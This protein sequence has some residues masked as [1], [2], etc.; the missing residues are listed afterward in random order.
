MNVKVNYKFCWKC[1]DI[2]YNEADIA[3]ILATRKCV[4]CD[5]EVKFKKEL[6][7][8]AKIKNKRIIKV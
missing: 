7:A 2:F 4:N 8:L 5:K 1:D 3:S 6:V